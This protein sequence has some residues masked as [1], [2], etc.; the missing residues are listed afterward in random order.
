MFSPKRFKLSKKIK[1]ALFKSIRTKCEHKYKI[2]LFLFHDFYK[3][4]KI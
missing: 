2:T 1:I 4:V 3:L